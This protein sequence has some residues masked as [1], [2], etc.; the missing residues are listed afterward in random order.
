[1]K[2]A[3]IFG[4]TGFIGLHFTRYLL[5]SADFGRIV[6]VDLKPPH[7]HLASTFVESEL[8]TGRVV[9]VNA[10]VRH[11]LHTAVQL[12]PGQTVGLVANFAAVHREPGHLPLE[13]FETNILGARNVCAYA[14]SV[15]CD[16]IIFTSSI[17]PYG[18]SE[19]ARDETSMTTPE[20]PYGS[21]KLAAELIHEAWRNKDSQSRRL[22]T[23][24]PGVVFGPGEGGNVSRLV[25]ALA[26]GFFVYAGNQDTRKSGIYV[27]ELCRAIWWLHEQQSNEAAGLLTANMSMNPGPSMQ[28]YVEAA[29]KIGE[30]KAWVPSVPVWLLMGSASVIHALGRPFGL[31]QSVNPVRVRKIIRSNNILP[32]VLADRGYPYL[33][34]LEG[35]FR[36]WRE[37]TPDEW[38]T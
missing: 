5:D 28:E 16:D 27:K 11:A 13:Y 17:S 9:Y 31:L 35:A 24:R 21:S 26:R 36:D 1:M 37:S 10:D 23:V 12:E 8:A 4:G 2:V 18:P 25:K 29:I 34:S 3:V 19:S 30:K 33:F 20:T 7:Q 38:R 6:L 15:G 22:L 14:E 32:K